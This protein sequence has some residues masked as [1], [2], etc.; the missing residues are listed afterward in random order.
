MVDEVLEGGEAAASVELGVVVAGLEQDL[1]DLERHFDL[2][3]SENARL[4]WMPLAG[5][6]VVTGRD[7]RPVIDGAVEFLS[8]PAGSGRPGRDDP[9]AACW[10]EFRARWEEGREVTLRWLDEFRRN[11]LRAEK[12]PDDLVEPVLDDPL[13]GS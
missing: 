8:D 6:Q 13:P 5:L 11:T 4:L 7:P 1:E 10:R 3:Q 9:D 12:V 2:F